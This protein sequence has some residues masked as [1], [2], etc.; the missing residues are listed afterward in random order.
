MYLPCVCSLLA[1]ASLNSED[2][3]IIMIKDEPQ[4]GSDMEDFDLPSF[5][6]T[7][8]PFCELVS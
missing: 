7:E 5:N 1:H 4:Y 8:T 6:I 3:D 2:D